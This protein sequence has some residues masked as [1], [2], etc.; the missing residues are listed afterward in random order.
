LVIG[1]FTRR[2]DRILLVV[3][4]AFLFA[5]YFLMQ[6]YYF[7]WLAFTGCFYFSSFSLDEKMEYKELL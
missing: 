5:D 4:C 3:F 1:L 2:Y 7:I 6:I